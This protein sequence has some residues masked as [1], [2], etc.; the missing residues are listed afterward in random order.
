M[1]TLAIG[2][3]TTYPTQLVVMNLFGRLNRAA[4]ESPDGILSGVFTN[5][6]IAPKIRQDTGSFQNVSY[7]LF[8]FATLS[9]EFHNVSV[10]P[11]TPNNVGGSVTNLGRIMIAAQCT[12]LN[13]RFTNFSYVYPPGYT[14]NDLTLFA[15]S[16]TTLS[17]SFQ[18]MSFNLGSGQLYTVFGGGV[19]IG[20]ETFSGNF[21]NISLF[22]PRTTASNSCFFNGS[23]LSGTFIDCRATVGNYEG[24]CAGAKNSVQSI[25]SGTFINCGVTVTGNN[26]GA[27]NNFGVFG[28]NS[29]NAAAQ[30]G[31]CSGYFKGCYHRVVSTTNTT[32]RVETFAGSLQG[33]ASGYFEDCEI[34]VGSVPGTF[35]TFGGTTA[36]GF[37]GTMMN[38]RLQYTWPAIVT[39]T[40]Q[41]YRSDFTASGATSSAITNIQNG[42][43]LAY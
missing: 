30:R 8:N 38:C 14:N 21:Q 16:G 29:G 34:T 33:E 26:T 1:E 37:S 41:I 22:S 40:A 2:T 36:Q 43:K 32:T 12:T 20:T 39:G 42:A 3:G 18:N 19:T 24:V 15:F 17:G 23:T 25:L 35:R 27:D 11:F 31:V 6:N 10:T 7:E 5:I 4:G 28:G 13:G 9:G